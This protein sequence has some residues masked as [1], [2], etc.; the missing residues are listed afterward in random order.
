[1]AAITSRAFAL[2][3][4]EEKDKIFLSEN[5]KNTNNA[6]CRLVINCGII[7]KQYQKVNLKLYFDYKILNH[8]HDLN[9]ILRTFNNDMNDY[10][11]D[12]EFSL[13]CYV[14]IMMSDRLISIQKVQLLLQIYQAY[15]ECQI[16]PSLV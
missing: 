10:S 8:Y 5:G 14:D 2:Y 1:M 12:F 15:L 3:L 4:I 7:T 11:D 6:S 9:Q 16:L 13:P